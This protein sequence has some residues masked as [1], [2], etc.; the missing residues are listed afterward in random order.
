MLESTNEFETVLFNVYIKVNTVPNDPLFNNQWNLTKVDIPSAW[1]IT[2]GSS[3]IIIAVIDVGADY[4][5]EDLIANKWG[6]TGGYDFISNDNDPYPYDGARHGT[7]VAGIISATTNNGIG[8]SGITGGWN[9]Q[10]GIKIMHLRAGFVDPTLGETMTSSAIAQAIDWAASHSA[11]IVNMSF[12]IYRDYN[13]VSEA[14]NNAF[15]DYGVIF[16]AASGNYFSDTNP[17]DHWIS[18][19]A[20]CD[21]CQGLISVGAT[22]ENDFRKSLNDGTDEP[23]WGS[24]YGGDG[25]DLD[26]V[27]PGIHI[28]TTDITGTSGYSTGNY[29]LT[30]NGTSSAAPHVAGLVGLIRSINP[31]LNF[32]DIYSII[33]NSVTKVVGMGGQNYHD[34]YGYG[35]ID[36]Y[37]A[38]LLTHAYSRKSISSSATSSSSQRK[39]VYAGTNNHHI[40]FSSGGEVF[41]QKTTDGGTNWQTPIRLSTGNGENYYPSICVGVSNQIMAAWSRKTTTSI[42]DIH[43]AMST[44]GGATWPA[45]YKYVLASPVSST[46]APSPV[47]TMN[48]NQSNL[49]RTVVYSSTL[50]LTAKTTTTNPPTSGSWTT[51]Q[52]T[53]SSSDIAPTLASCGTSAYNILAYRNGSNICYRYQN[54]DGSGTWSSCITLS[55]MI[56]GQSWNVA[57]TICGMPSDGSVHLAWTRYTY[58]GGY[59]TSPRNFYMKN[60]SA[61]GS[62]PYQYWQVTSGDQYTPSITALASNKI[63][64]LYQNSGAYLYKS[65]FNGSSWGSPTYITYSSKDP[66]VSIGNTSAKYVYAGIYGSPFQV[67]MGSE[68][69]TKENVFENIEKYYSRSVAFIEPEGSFVEYILH[70]I[71]V[72]EEDNTETLTN[73]IPAILEDKNLSTIDAFDVQSSEYFVLDKDA[74]EIVVDYNINSMNSEKVVNDITKPVYLVVTII[75]E[76]GKQ[77][78]TANKLIDITQKSETFDRR[79]ITIP[80][81]GITGNV[82]IKTYLEGLEANK[83]TIVSLGHLYDYPTIATEKENVTIELKTETIPT[84]YSLSN[85]PNPFNPSTKIT[86]SLL[87][88]GK[89][90]LRIYDVLGRLIESVKENEVKLPGNYEVTFNANELPSGVYFYTLTSS[91]FVQTRKMILAK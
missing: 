10:N 61:N 44:D 17:E 86:F 1:D 80:I 14:I 59:P 84:S 71:K 56:P 70:D 52:I 78:N 8:I 32:T 21:G 89:I 22:V 69:L 7:A 77:L 81:S 35:R 74:K 27:A 49:R 90:S 37:Q 73:M 5:H 38:L 55:T 34:E 54:N 42:Y 18:Y 11:D 12:E 43:F 50:G 36:A 20:N 3:E 39:I 4:N 68:V 47:I 76:N 2:K 46:N 30:F 62:W 24:R 9:S 29:H 60:A 16:V 63:D 79:S 65:R 45:T 75:D 88:E 31:N 40:I 13:I 25:K 67:T 57:P 83:E 51:Q 28:P 85:Y 91:D 53:T 33:S 6:L 26:F 23:L 87:K 64:L 48:Q 72:S 66:S 19:P 82:K 41:Y 58:T 15:N